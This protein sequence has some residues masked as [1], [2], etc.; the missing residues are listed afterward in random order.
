MPV[1]LNLTLCILIGIKLLILKLTH[2]LYLPQIVTLFVSS[3][4]SKK[5]SV[6]CHALGQGGPLLV[7]SR[8]GYPE[9][10]KSG[11]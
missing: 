5:L 3:S 9:W 4:K 10:K 7:E 11:K 8:I 2:M 1:I 6:D